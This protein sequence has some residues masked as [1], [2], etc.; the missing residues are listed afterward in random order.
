MPILATHLIHPLSDRKVEVLRLLGRLGMVLSTTI[1]ELLFPELHPTT[2]NRLL[3]DL[4]RRKLIWSASMPNFT[5]SA[6]GRSVGSSP[7]V[8]GLTDDGKAE[9]AAYELEP[10]T[11]AFSIDQLVFR[12]RA[13]SAPPDVGSLVINA[14][15]STWVASLLDQ[16]RRLPMLIGVNAQRAYTIKD[17]RGN[18]AQKMGALVVLRF[19]LQRT[20]FDRRLWA[21][22][23]APDTSHDGRG[24]WMEVRLA[25]EIDNGRRSLQHIAETIAVYK[26]Y[27]GAGVYAT[28]FG[29]DLIPVQITQPGERAAQV[30]ELW[31]RGWEG[32]P[33]LLSTP[34]KTNHDTLGVL[35]GDY[36]RLRQRPAPGQRV[37]RGPLLGTALGSLEAWIE[38]TSHWEAMVA[39]ERAAAPR[40]A[41]IVTPTPSARSRTRQAP[42]E[43]AAASDPPRPSMEDQ[44]PPPA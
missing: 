36:I 23:W 17:D 44:G 7:H 1:H 34:L 8:Y 26:A 29:G 27:S 19:D 42:G 31:M 40:R 21:I 14:Y 43:Q 6:S 10:T 12:P 13:S 24:R 32:N 41:A 39:Q 30:A 33:A 37:E 4:V 28:L 9:L 38:R 25:L 15:I 22:P 5:R 2:R 18:V 3:A 11:G 20:V 35:W 16:V